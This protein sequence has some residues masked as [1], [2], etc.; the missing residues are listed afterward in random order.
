MVATLAVNFERGAL[1]GVQSLYNALPATVAMLGA[2]QG[3]KFGSGAYFKQQLPP[4]WPELA[5]DAVAGGSSA[6]T[7]T[8][9]L[10]PLDT[11]KTRLQLGLG[12]PAMHQLYYGYRP[13]VTYSAFGMALW[14]VSRNWLERTLPD[15]RSVSRDGLFGGLLGSYYPKHFVCGGLAG[16]FVQIPT[17]PFDTLKKRL[18]AAEASTGALDEAR[19]LLREGG[20]QRFYRGFLVKTLFVA[21]N[22]ALF[23]TVF[24]ACR[25]LLR[26]EE[27]RTSRSRPSSGR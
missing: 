2:R 7:S 24:V 3:L 9:L 15:P 27:P 22:G 20:P 10:F 17:F 5:K 13:A 14:V 1:R 12:V 25:K 6:A 4:E 16:V 18:Q 23:N 26:V 8:T 21:L 19:R 11:L